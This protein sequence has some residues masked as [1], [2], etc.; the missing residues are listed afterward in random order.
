MHQSQDVGEVLAHVLAQEGDQQCE[1]LEEEL[2]Q[3]VVTPPHHPKQDRHHLQPL[4]PHLG[5]LLF[6]P[7]FTSDY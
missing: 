2:S 3:G 6:S 5:K 7:C 4:H 1:L